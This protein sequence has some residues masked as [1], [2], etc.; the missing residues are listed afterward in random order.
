MMENGLR[1]T[2][3]RFFLLSLRCA[4]TSQLHALLAQRIATSNKNHKR[5]LLFEPSDPTTGRK[6]KKGVRCERA[7]SLLLVVT[8]PACVCVEKNRERN[9]KERTSWCSVEYRAAAAAACR[10]AS[11]FVFHPPPTHNAHTMRSRCLVAVVPPGRTAYA[12]KPYSVRP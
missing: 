11:F 4:F 10:R 3:V 5:I 7:T 12:P 2:L 8:S 6:K 1:V 9:E